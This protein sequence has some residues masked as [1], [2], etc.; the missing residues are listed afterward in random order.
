MGFN[1]SQQL[2]SEWFDEDLQEDQNTIRVGMRPFKV[3]EEVCGRNV[4]RSWNM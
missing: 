3:E 1:K 2:V 4:R